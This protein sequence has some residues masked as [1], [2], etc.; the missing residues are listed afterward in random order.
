MRA[1]GMILLAA[2]LA[3]GVSCGDDDPIVQAPTT[4]VETPV[5]ITTPTVTPSLPAPTPSGSG[6]AILGAPSPEVAA[7]RLYGYWLAED[8]LGARAVA[9]QD[10]IDQLFNSPPS[11]IEFTGCEPDGVRFV[12]FFYYEGGGLNIIVDP[13]P[14]NGYVAT[15]AFFIAD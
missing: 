10:A 2:L 14:P 12:C 13:A 1:A 3:L 15:R 5:V 6:P 7:R 8:P 4:I 11:E 9:E